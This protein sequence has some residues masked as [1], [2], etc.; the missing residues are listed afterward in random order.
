MDVDATED[1]HSPFNEAERAECERLARRY[2]WRFNKIKFRIYGLIVISE[3]QGGWP[4][5]AVQINIAA[6]KKVVVATCMAFMRALS[7]EDAPVVVMKA[8]EQTRD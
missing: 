6:E 8:P 5:E 2:Y 1:K 4:F 7:K 3:D